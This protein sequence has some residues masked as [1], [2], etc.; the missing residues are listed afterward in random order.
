MWEI[1]REKRIHLLE[2]L[3]EGA[4]IRSVERVEHVHRDSLIRLM[5]NAGFACEDVLDDRI[6]NLAR[7]HWE[8]DE[9]WTFCRKKQRK[10]TEE[11]KADRELGDQYLYLAIGQ[12]NKLIASY[13]IGKR[14]DETTRK[15]IHDFA[16]RLPLAR[17]FRHR[18]STDGFEPYVKALKEAFGKAVDYGTITKKFSKDEALI[19]RRAICGTFDENSICTSHVE[20][21][22][23]SIRHFLRRFT[24]KSLGFS[25]KHENLRA[26]VAL[27]VAH[28]NFCRVHGTINATPAMVAG[29]TERPWTMERLLEEVGFLRHY[30]WEH[31]GAGL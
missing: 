22:N 16:T 30:S 6:R 9:L 29:L 23:L 26:A 7:Q 14:D 31:E 20:R 15:F 19:V 24:R 11:E 13:W 21:K 2:W 1:R 28:Y 17:S 8:I 3:V 5:V 4:G 18:I 27:H 25:K 12:T 10:L